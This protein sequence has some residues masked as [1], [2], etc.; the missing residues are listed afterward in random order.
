MNSSR[1]TR[2][3]E[4]EVPAGAGLADRLPSDLPPTSWSLLIAAKDD[5]E[6]GRAA[7]EVFARRYYPPIEAYLL[8]LSGDRDEAR[9]VAQSFFLECVLSGA[10]IAR[11]DGARGRFRH[12]LKRAVR[13]FYVDALRSRSRA[14]R[15]GG[16][17]PHSLEAASDAPELRTAG[18]AA[19][20]AAFHTAW[21]R[22][23]LDQ[24]LGRVRDECSRRGQSRHY[25]VFAGRYL[26]PGGEEPAWADIGARHGLD[27]KAARGRAETVARRFRSV[28]HELLAA[29][30]GS[31]RAA[32]DEIQ[33]LLA[34]L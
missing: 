34:V 4:V 12:Y 28:L 26:N 24:A 10:I 29:E 20:D 32:D 9:D 17:A 2:K 23:L 8:A 22:A 21:V 1:A 6:A 16:A 33:R 18:S 7:R 14:R 15:G 30:L 31:R 5:N 27:E 19:P 25:D 11:A 3:G 13:N